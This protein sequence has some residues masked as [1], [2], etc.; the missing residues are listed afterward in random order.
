MHLAGKTVFLGPQ[1]IA[2]FLD[3]CAIALASEG[4]EVIAFKKGFSSLHPEIKKNPRINWLFSGITKKVSEK[5]SLIRFTTQLVL[6]LVALFIALK[7][8]DACIF[9]GGKGLFNYPIDYILFRIFQIRVIHMFVGTASRPRFMSGY[10]KKILTPQKKQSKVLTRRL[11]KRTKRQR[12]R[13]QLISRT[14]NCVV[15]N[16]L[17]GHFQPKP[18]VNFF[19]LGIPI[20]SN[21]SS[22]EEKNSSKT[23]ILHCPSRPDIKGT[24]QIINEL[25]NEI[26]DD[27]NAELIVLTG[28]PHKTVIEEIKKCDFVIDQLYSDSPLAGFAAEAASYGK[29][30][31]VGGYGWDELKKS[32]NPDDLPPSFLCKPSEL[33]ASV[34]YLCLNENKRNQLSTKLSKFLDQGEW[35]QANFAKKLSRIISNEIPNEWFVNPTSISY[36]YGMGLKKEECMRILKEMDTFRGNS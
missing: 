33:I 18:F 35:S 15:E 29:V 30:P 10:S 8:A 32:L 23:R 5:N 24:D 21:S 28:V 16:P 25:T 12:K 2:G 6:K 14:A 20:E 4:A 17:C 31:I 22:A 27:L 7:K 13:I 1:E 11:L 9:I 34:K 3:R 36:R 26:L 19:K